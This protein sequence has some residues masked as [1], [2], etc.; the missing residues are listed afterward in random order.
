M[1]PM[2]MR[3]SCALLLAAL[4]CGC[5]LIDPAAPPMG[6]SGIEGSGLA[7]RPPAMRPSP[8]R[9]RAEPSRTVS[10]D[11]LDGEAF[12]GRRLAAGD[13]VAIDE[14]VELRSGEARLRVPGDLSYLVTGPARLRFVPA[15]DRIA[16]W[17]ESGTVQAPEAGR[18]ITPGGAALACETPFRVT[19]DPS[20]TR[21]DCASGSLRW[22]V[23]GSIRPIAG[24]GS[25]DE[26]SR[27]LTAR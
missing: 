23:D 1:R 14:T 12:A 19:R 11:A 13:R 21:F 25:I 27:V 26:A 16:V 15:D 17:L 7:A 10:V 3:A 22:G 9:A 8:V 20:A 6:G 4:A 18:V 5:A 2:R 24:A